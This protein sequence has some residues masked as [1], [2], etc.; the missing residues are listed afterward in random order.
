MMQAGEASTMM[1]MKDS[2]TGTT[3]TLNNL[4]QVL[5][6]HKITKE[7]FYKSFHYY[8]AHPQYNKI[9]FDSIAAYSARMRE[10][11]FR[12]IQ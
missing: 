8:Q 1:Y 2:V 12:T 9:L 4:Q 3:K 6:I 5:A 10:N 11:R 7:A